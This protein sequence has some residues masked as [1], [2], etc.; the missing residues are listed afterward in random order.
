MGPIAALNHLLNFV[1]PALALALGVTLG[2]YFFMQKRP[3]ALSPRAQ[4]AINL[5]VN[6]MVLA[7]GLLLRAL[8]LRLLALALRLRRL[9]HSRTHALR[10]VR[11]PAAQAGRRRRRGVGRG[12]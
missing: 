7:L 5:I 1:A 6:C 9:G 2:A 10:R 4:F 12:G 8:V 11:R 3:P